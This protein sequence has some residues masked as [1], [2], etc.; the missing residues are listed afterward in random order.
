MNGLF[1][2][3]QAAGALETPE[4]E[5]QNLLQSIEGFAQAFTDPEKLATFAGNILAAIAIYLVGKIVVRILTGLLEKVMDRAKVD[6][7]LSSFLSNIAHCVL[8][9]FVILMAL[10]RLG[11]NTTSLAAIMGAAGLAVGLALQS[12]LSN[13]ASGVMIILFKPFR[14]GD[15]IEAAGVS[16]TVEEISIFST[17]M[18]TGDNKQIIVPNGSIYGGNITN[19]SAK[20]T[21]RIDM[22]VGCGYGDDLRAVKAFLTILVETDE[23][24]LKDPAP[25]VAVSELGD[26]SVNFVVRPWVNSADYWAVLWDLNERVKL[27]F[28][29]RGFNIPY[30]TQDIHVHKAAS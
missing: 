13:F 16:G 6:A 11:V 21:R 9:T 17:L 7:T 15:F 10:E 20:P 14:V 25:V 22:V 23:R 3:A 30:P 28:D 5:P 4:P 27:G 2:L 26:S 19:Y 29:E 1:L 12:S 24:I 8:I 18:K